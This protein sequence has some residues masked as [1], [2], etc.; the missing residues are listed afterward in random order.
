MSRPIFV[1]G[2]KCPDT[3]SIAAAIAYA[4]LQNQ[5]GNQA[6]P[7]RAGELNKETS[8]ALHYFGL[9]APRLV[10]TLPAE[11]QAEKQKIILVD[12]NESKQ[13]IDGIDNAQVIEVIDHHRLGDFETEGP[14][15][16]LFRPVGCVDTIIYGLY[17][18]HHIEIPRQIAG[19]ML[20]AIISDTVLFRSP[21]TTEAD[22]EAVRDLAKIA[23]VDYEK[24]GMEMLKAGAD[25]SDY[26]AEKLAQNDTK[27]FG[28]GNHVFTVGQISV[29]DTD[30][31][32]K[33]KADIMSA[34][35]ENRRKGGYAASFLMVTD[36]L[37]EDTYLWYTG[38]ED[39]LLVRAF[40]KKPE[41]Y[42]VHLPGVMSRK[43]Q[44]TP[45][46]LKAFE[47]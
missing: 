28:T 7:I 11:D 18:C 26:T 15:S 16:I 14:I 2:H 19:I 27:E 21:T 47:N 45:F 22:K 29:M 13:C 39:S 43:K 6:E 4:Y 12:H 5:I 44:V 40:G 3:D 34:L 9:E 10:E 32:N 20:S 23:E 30:P 1:C 33:K 38:C 42:S 35:E 17:Q 24:Y 46:L 8:F 37:K 25:I 36:I 31:I 41:N